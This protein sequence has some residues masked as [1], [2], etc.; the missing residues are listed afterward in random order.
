MGG[1][2]DEVWFSLYRI[3]QLE[4]IKAKPWPEVMQ[5]YLTAYEF[6]PD[7]AGPLFHVGMN[8]HRRGAITAPRIS[9]SAAQ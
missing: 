8:Y 5:H 6:M 4:Q 9:S 3:A 1:H 7:R 2:N